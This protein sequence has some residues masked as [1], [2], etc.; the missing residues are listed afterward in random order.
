M[1]VASLVREPLWH[2]SLIPERMVLTCILPKKVPKP[3]IRPMYLDSLVAH[4]FCLLN[5]LIINWCLI[6]YMNVLI[7]EVSWQNL[8]L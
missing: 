6:F 7:L 2:C 4:V 8:K 5:C 1:G 3:L